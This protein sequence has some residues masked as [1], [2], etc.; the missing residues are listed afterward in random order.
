[1]ISC[2][3]IFLINSLGLQVFAQIRE[4]VAQLYY[5]FYV[6]MWSTV[7]KSGME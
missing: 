4:S 5:V 1:M 7:F 6:P 2:Y 3:Q